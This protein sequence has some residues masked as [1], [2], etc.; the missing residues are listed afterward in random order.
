MTFWKWPWTWFHGKARPARTLSVRT[1]P[2]LE[3]LEERLV[4]SAGAVLDHDAWSVQRFALDTFAAP[5]AQASGFGSLIGLDSV[6]AN[7]PYRGN[8]YSVAVLD[9]GIDYNHAALGGGW[10]KRIVAGYDFVNNDND[11]MDDNGHGTH[12]A[13]ILGANSAAFSGVA[14]GVNLIALKVLDA[15]GSGSFGD[16]EEALQWVMAHRAQYNIVAVNVSLGSGNYSTNP[17]TFLEDE[18]GALKSQGVFLATAAGNSYFGFGSQPGLGYPAISPSTVGVGAVWTGN[19]GAM[20]WISGARDHSTAADRI[21]SFSQRST[22]LDIFAPGAL[23]SSTWLHNG[24]RNMAGTSMAT[25]VIAGAAAL[26]HQALD[27]NGQAGKANQEHILG[28]MKSTGDIVVDG[29]DENDNVTNTGLSFK[30]LDLMA[31][32]ASI[33]KGNRPP[34]LGPIADR[35]MSRGQA[36][37]SI[38]LAIAD[39][40]GNS[41]SRSAAVYQYSAAFELDQRF[42][43]FVDRGYWHNSLRANEKWLRGAANNKWYS[44]EPSGV[45]R[46]WLSGPLASSPIVATLDGSYWNNPT[47]LVN[48][49]TPS[50]QAGVTATFSGNN[51]IVD[52]PPS[53]VGPILVRVQ[54]S[55][56]QA[57]VSRIFKVTVNNAAPA[58][59]A[60][61]DRTMPRT[62]SNLLVPLSVVDADGDSVTLSAMAY[63]Y[64]AAFELEQR[65]DLYSTGNL[66]QNY[67]G[68]N[69]KWLR[70]RLNGKWYT[71]EPS[72]VVREW[73]GG[74]VVNSPVVA[75]LKSM[76]WTNP[77]LLHNAQGAALQTISLRIQGRTLTVDPPAAFKGSFLVVVGASDGVASARRVFRVTTT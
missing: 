55:D 28:L 50:A 29:D 7:Y 26:L 49:A 42:D 68:L 17:F 71:I 65:L 16:V 64:S 39:P 25:P 72:G 6:F 15:K 34:T 14:P 56:G 2:V 63:P 46:E 24:Y 51:L 58:L 5:Q 13:G 9:T 8:G 40:D 37:I 54:V 48:V 75:T 32:L 22:Q 41:L 23:I 12:V 53:L 73:T 31:A 61:A 62:Q 19:F 45:V 35:T 38:P 36:S 67:S 30:R 33:A 4:L 59:A 74:S 44:I 47:R 57:S 52:P 1:R 60:L 18:F 76:H 43:L 27:A 77:S 21:A 66:W 20:S 3:P 70:S 10:G 69:E 11:P